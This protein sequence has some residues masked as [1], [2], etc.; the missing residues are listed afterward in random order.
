MKLE[1][2]GSSRAPLL[3]GGLLASW[4]LPSHPSDAQGLSQAVWPTQK[5]HNTVQQY[6]TGYH[7]NTGK[8]HNTCI[9]GSE[10]QEYSPIHQI[11]HLQIGHFFSD[12]F[13]RWYMLGLRLSEVIHAWS[14]QCLIISIWGS[15]RLVWLFL[16]CILRPLSDL[17]AFP[18]M[19]HLKVSSPCCRPSPGSIHL[20]GDTY[21]SRVFPSH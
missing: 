2:Y 10:Q 1:V 7:H 14:L 21:R 8:H 6:N 17:K 16:L 19:W 18:Q 9:F 15:S 20:S 13:P 12:G 3:A 5:W 4:L 11:V